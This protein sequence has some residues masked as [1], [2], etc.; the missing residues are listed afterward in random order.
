MTRP[1]LPLTPLYNASDLREVEQQ[2]AAAIARDGGVPLMERAGLAAAECVR[3][4]LGEGGTSVLIFA[5]PGNN[6]GDA[7]VAAR[8]LRAWFHRVDVVLDADPVRLPADAAQ[9]LAQWHAAGGTTL[10]E[11]PPHGRWQLAIDGLFGIGLKRALEGPFARRVAQI[12]A[13]G[14]PVLALDLPSGLDADTGSVHGC[15]VAATRTITFLAL[16]PGLLTA[17]GPDHCGELE[18]A[19]LGVDA[20]RLHPPSGHVVDPRQRWHP[21]KRGLAPF[22]GDLLPPRRRNSHKGSYGSVGILGGAPGMVGAALLAARAALLAGAGRVSVGLIDEDGPGVDPLQP[23]LM[24]RA[25]H[26]LPRLEALSVLAAGPGLGDTPES[27]TALHWA[28]GRALPLVLDADALNLIA[29]L[30]SLREALLARSAPTILTPHPAEAARL[31]GRDSRTVQA[32]RIAAAC[33]LSRELRCAVVLKGCGSISALEGGARWFIHASGNPG[34]AS[35]GMGDS[36]TGVI[37][38]LLAQELSAEQALIGGVS[39]HGAAADAIVAE[40]GARD[41]LAGLTA[42]EVSLRVRALLNA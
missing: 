38:G 8:W 21:T 29:R 10:S 26:E 20:E 25:W 31:L 23:E 22:F 7:L 39:V 3:A 6:G 12:N 19:T 24:L 1:A 15:A 9:A 33:S 35:A 13:L 40:H 36:L 14:I 4:M 30:P 18:L 2:A 16:K 17:D 34:M 32:D 5:G 42:S 41:A 37:A 28:L 11:P 27:Y